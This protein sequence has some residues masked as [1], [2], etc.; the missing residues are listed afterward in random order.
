MEYIKKI[1]NLLPGRKRQ[2]EGSLFSVTAYRDWRIIISVFVV[3]GLVVA[4]GSLYLLYEISYGSIFATAPQEEV[5]I[6]SINLKKLNDV[7]NFYQ[8]KKDALQAL[9]DKTTMSPDPSL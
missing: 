6:D 1:I 9:S 5:I 2:G 3:I 8:A 4:L 7:V